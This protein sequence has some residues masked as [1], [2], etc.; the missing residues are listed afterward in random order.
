MTFYISMSYVTRKRI[1]DARGRWQLLEKL[2][3]ELL[4]TVWMHERF[5]PDGRQQND[6]TSHYFEYP[7]VVALMVSIHS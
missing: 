4:A 6:R 1:H 5:G 3:D 2:T 7:A